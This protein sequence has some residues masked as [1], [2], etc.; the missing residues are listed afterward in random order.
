MDSPAN[1]FN[2]TKLSRRKFGILIAGGATLLAAGGSYGVIAR[3]GAGPATALAMP[4]GEITILRAGRFARLDAQGHT[5]M[6]H[7]ADSAARLGKQDAGSVR[8]VGSPVQ[9]A[10]ADGGSHGSGGHGHGGGAGDPGW[11]QPVNLTWGDVVVLEMDIHNA[12][13]HPVPF[14]SG[15]LRLALSGS[16]V[17]VTPRD[18]NLVPG[19]LAAYAR[20]RVLISYLA[21]HAWT[22]FELEVSDPQHEQVRRLALPALATAGASS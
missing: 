22:G 7:L 13:N 17:T 15:Q 18:S 9:A 14:S 8:R 19:L 20:E 2:A 10:A 21:P 3:S 1:S 5:A 12:Q 6:S 16:N 4:F 11:P